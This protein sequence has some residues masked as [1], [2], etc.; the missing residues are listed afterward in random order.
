MQESNIQVHE[1]VIQ[2]LNEVMEKN[3]QKQRHV[4]I[5]DTIKV[6]SKSHEQINKIIKEDKSR[7][8]F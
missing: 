8:V 2:K 1:K 7:G 3:G 4:T 5:F 6:S